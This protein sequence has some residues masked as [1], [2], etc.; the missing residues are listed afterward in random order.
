MAP[1]Q[2]R[3]ARLGKAKEATKRESTEATILANENDL[4]PSSTED[5]YKEEEF[6]S[7]QEESSFQP[8]LQPKRRRPPLTYPDLE[9]RLKDLRETTR[10]VSIPPSTGNRDA[11]ILWEISIV[12]Q[13]SF[14]AEYNPNQFLEVL[15]KV[16][17][18]RDV[19]LQA[20]NLLVREKRK[21]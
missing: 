8:L 16:R 9:N 13:I 10:K 1:P 11:V 4:Q 3:T 18:E 19:G 5:E 21:R 2:L 7:P 15:N 14:Q 20:S 12:A 6:E 17:E